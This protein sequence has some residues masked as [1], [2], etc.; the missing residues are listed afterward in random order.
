MATWPQLLEIVIVVFSLLYVV[1]IARE[2]RLGWWF[3]VAASLLSVPLFIHFNLLAE[4]A[5]YAFYTVI[6][7]YG[8]FSWKYPQR[9]GAPLQI[10]CRPLCFHLGVLTVGGILAGFLAW[11]LIQAG[12]SF[13]VVDACT[14]VFAVITTWM[15][16]RKILENWLYWIVIDIVSAWLYWAKGMPVYALLMLLYTVLAAAGFIIWYRRL[17]ASSHTG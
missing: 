8:W 2:N 4:A 7:L 9:G 1:L 5:L 10:S 12:S 3:G 16:T 17:R 11:A 13:P 6:G 14:T 15:A